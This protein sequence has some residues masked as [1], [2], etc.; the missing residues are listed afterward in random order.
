VPNKPR[1]YSRDWKVPTSIGLWGG[2]AGDRCRLAK[3]IAGRIDPV[4]QWLQ[5]E[6]SL[7]ATDPTEQEFLHQ[8]PSGRLFLL[9]PS[10]LTPRPELGNLASWFVREDIEADTRIRALADF[11]RLPDFARN[12][13]EN[14]SRHSPTKALVIANFDHARHLYPEIAGEVRPIIEAI[15]EY[16]TTLLITIT[17]EP[18]ARS[19]SL[20][21]LLHIDE[22]RTPAGHSRVSVECRQGP[23]AGTQ[24]LFTIGQRSDLNALIEE[25]ERS[26]IGN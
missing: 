26:P 8:L 13:L 20:D 21:Y 9:N 18:V 14:R 24:G 19:A 12:L 1:A 10:D 25:L 16:A 22:N 7:A 11:M 2:S 5:V 6:D 3:A 23:S 4:Y 15:N 17:R